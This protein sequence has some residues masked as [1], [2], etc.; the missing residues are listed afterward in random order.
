MKLC[1]V[2]YSKR[3]LRKFLFLTNYYI[4]FLGW[5]TESGSLSAITLVDLWETA[6]INDAEKL[7]HN[8]GFFAKE[9]KILDLCNVLEE[10]IQ[11]QNNDEMLSVLLKVWCLC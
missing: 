5:S 10:E 2:S 4:M 11:R 8:L 6:G 9:V 7:L 3:N 1:R